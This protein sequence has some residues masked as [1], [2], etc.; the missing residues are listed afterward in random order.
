VTALPRLLVSGLSGFVGSW[1][2]RLAEP[3]WQ[4]VPLADPSGRSVEITN[5]AA[6]SAAVMAVRPDAVLHLAAQS[7]V[8]DSF[9]DPGKTLQIN[10]FGTLNLLQGLDA[11]AFRGSLVLASSGDTYGLVDV[12]DL[13]IRE[14]QPQRPRNP[15]AVSKL[16]AEALAW[17][18]GQ[19]QHQFRIHVAR[20]FN[21]VGPGQDARFAVADFALQVAAIRAGRQAP[22]LHVGDIDATRDF[23]DVR[24]VVAAY[25]PL[26]TLP[27]SS[28]IFNV[29]SGRERTLREIIADLCRLAGIAPELRQDLA[30][31]RP[32]EQR[33]VCGSPARLHAATGW[34]AVTP[35]ETTLRDILLDAEHVIASQKDHP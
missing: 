32:S 22:V 15:Y 9:R 14:E 10:L 27:S 17:Q 4:V 7:N 29:C 2:Q 5:A 1:V 6:V 18:W 8:P 19:T 35:W 11:C 20:A 12:K 33:R 34:T 16:A 21:H 13:P 3:T 28:G 24:D 26:L 31:M 25:L 30:R 23:T